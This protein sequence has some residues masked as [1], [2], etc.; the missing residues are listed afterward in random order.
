[1]DRDELEEKIDGLERQLSDMQ[2]FVYETAKPKLD[3]QEQL[4]EEHQQ[5]LERLRQRVDSAEETSKEGKVRDIVMYAKNRRNSETVVLL[6][7]NE[8]KG[9]AGCSRRYAYDLMDDIPHEYDWA[10]TPEDIRQYGDL[11]IKK[12]DESRRLGIDFK[13][14][15]SGGVSMNLFTTRSEGM[16]DQ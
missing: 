3:E 13:G 6:T 8:I 15:H 10:L 7:A 16:E 11:K 4:I 5:E 14:V 9:A 2:T 12:G 1:M